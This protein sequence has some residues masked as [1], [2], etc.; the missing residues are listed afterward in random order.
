MTSTETEAG[1]VMLKVSARKN[2][3]IANYQKVKRLRY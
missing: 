2:R 1:H 3:V